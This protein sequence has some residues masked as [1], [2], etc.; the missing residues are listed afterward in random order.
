MK[1]DKNDYAEAK[2]LKGSRK[3]RRA[4]RRESGEREKKKKEEGKREERRSRASGGD[5]ESYLGKEE[6]AK[7]KDKHKAED[8]GE[9][10][11]RKGKKEGKWGNP[12]GLLGEVGGLCPT[13]SL[14]RP[15]TGFWTIM[16]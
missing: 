2:I 12:P 10:A 7:K 4:W 13:W 5:R 14:K 1:T 16:I 9:K 15:L 6:K 8:L 11:K 3:S